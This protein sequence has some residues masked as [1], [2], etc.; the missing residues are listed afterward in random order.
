MSRGPGHV[1]RRILDY[2]TNDERELGRTAI[3]IAEE[4]YGA[5]DRKTARIFGGPELTDAQLGSVRRA[6]R[7]LEK[8]GL[9]FRE[10]ST[11]HGYSE[12][13]WK[14]SE[15]PRRRRRRDAP[16]F[17]FPSFSFAN[18]QVDRGLGERF[19]KILGLLGSDHAGERL[20]A[21]Q[22]AEELRRLK[23]LTWTE[24]VRE[25]ILVSQPANGGSED[26]QQPRPRA[27]PTVAT[28]R[29]LQGAKS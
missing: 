12:V 17:D 20:A 2:L 27:A 5:L 11:F 3:G 6:L 29:D 7:R 23:G 16:R 4:V 28:S 1:E 8:R 15:R 19:A 21:V 13:R 14:S 18:R 26:Q 24:I 10:Q 9:I 22:A 25:L